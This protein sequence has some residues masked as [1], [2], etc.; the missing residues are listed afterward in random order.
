MNCPVC[1]GSVDIPHAYSCDL[2]LCSTCLGGRAQDGMPP[3]PHCRQRA[4]ASSLLSSGLLPGETS[5]PVSAADRVPSSPASIAGNEARAVETA[6]EWIIRTQRQAE[7]KYHEIQQRQAYAE[8]EAQG[9]VRAQ[10]HVTQEQEW[11]GR[12]RNQARAHTQAAT[13]SQ[14]GGQAPATDADSSTSAQ[15]IEI[16]QQQILENEA[17]E[18]QRYQFL[19]DLDEAEERQRA[20]QAQLEDAQHQQFARDLE[21]REGARAV[22]VLPEVVSATTTSVTSSPRDQQT[23]TGTRPRGREAQF[24]PVW[25]E[26]EAEIRTRAVA[27]ERERILREETNHAEEERRWRLRVLAAETGRDVPNQSRLSRNPDDERHRMIHERAAAAEVRRQAI[28]LRKACLAAL[29]IVRQ[30]EAL[31]APNPN[32][33]C[34]NP[35]APVRLTAFTI[36]TLTHGAFHV[37]LPASAT[38]LELMERIYE[39]EGIPVDQQ[40]LIWNSRG[41]NEERRLDEYGLQTCDVIHVVL[42]IR[43]D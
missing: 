43:G 39:R 3:C 29:E 26:W 22:V 34:A 41:L 32:R 33:P 42:K 30:A 23:H 7:E 6:Y 21:E 24:R 5:L 37:V 8:V 27:E 19:R 2:L 36:K 11:A 12:A 14:P 18:A 4:P 16:E 10:A 31:R 40:R 9:A 25:A 38:V 17:E 35:I 15:I 13:Q 28:V 1:T 20:E